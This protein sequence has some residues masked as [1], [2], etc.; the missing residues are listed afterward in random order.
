MKS[1]YNGAAHSNRRSGSKYSVAAALAAAGLTLTTAQAQLVPNPSTGDLFIGFQQVNDAGGATTATNDYLVDIGPVSQFLNATAPFVVPNLG[2]LASDLSSS[3]LFG[4]DWADNSPANNLLVQWGIFGGGSNSGNITLN[5]DSIAKNT[6]F[7]TIGESTPGT[8]STAPLVTS[9]SAQGTIFAKIST[10]E[11]GTGGYQG[12]LASSN[13]PVATIQSLSAPNNYASFNPYT[14]AFN[15]S[16]GIEQPLS[17]SAT[18]PTNSV[19]DLYELT[20]TAHVVTP[21]PSAA[22]VGT[23]T[24]DNNANLTFTPTPEPSTAASVLGGSAV[25]G[26]VRRRKVSA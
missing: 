18:G 21:E 13:S 2:N 11:T 19:L 20:P 5:G 8:Q 25:L 9:T 12:S 1:H 16:Y 24:L 7:F 3:S 15:E 6:L 4:S 22:L 23:F 26:L 10:A 17:G 14:G